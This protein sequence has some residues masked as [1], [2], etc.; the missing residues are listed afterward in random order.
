MLPRLPQGVILSQ[1]SWLQRVD[2]NSEAIARGRVGQQNPGMRLSVKQ[3]I[4]PHD[5][6]TS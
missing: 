6:I 4:V 3:E 5:G 2:I 1:L